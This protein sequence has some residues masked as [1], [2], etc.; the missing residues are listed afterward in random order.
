MLW[1]YAAIGIPLSNSEGC[2][3][4]FTESH[5]EI[6]QAQTQMSGDGFTS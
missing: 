4:T 1:Y 6:H 3:M 5:Y 2:A